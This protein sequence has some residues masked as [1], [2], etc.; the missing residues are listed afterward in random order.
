MDEHTIKI[1]GQVAGIGGLALGVFFYLFRE[2]IRRNFFSKLTKRHSYDIIRLMLILIWSIAIVGIIAWIYAGKTSVAPDFKKYDLNKSIPFDTG[3][4]F[5]G[6]FDFDQNAYLEGPY[7]EIAYRPVKIE[8]YTDVAQIGDVL[9]ISK[10]RNVVIANYKT[11]G[12]KNQLISPA[13]LNE[14]LSEND[15]TG[16][17]LSKGMFVMVRDVEISASQGKRASIWCRVIECDLDNESCRKAIGN[18]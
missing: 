4:I 1:F 2:I 18:N 16:I 9:S 6:Y 14:V 7:A 3:W 5:I 11:Q 10:S 15:Y 17:K 8:Q 13:L 12:L